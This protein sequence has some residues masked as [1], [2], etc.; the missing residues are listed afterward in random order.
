MKCPP[1]SPYEAERLVALSK[2]RLG[3]DRALP[4]LDPVVRI[5]A[6][7]FDV[8]VA[9]VN[10]V[11]D[12]HVFFAAAKGIVAEEV[13]TS[14]DASFCAHAMLENDV[15]VVADATLDARFHD[16]PLVRG[17]TRV[18]FYAGVPIYSASGMPL[19]ALCIIDQKPNHH[20]SPDDSERLR[21][22][23]RM[24]T[25]RL[26]LRR[27]EMAAEMD[28]PTHAAIDAMSPTAMIR[29]DRYGHIVN[30]NISAAT[31]YGYDFDAWHGLHIEALIAERDRAVLRALI[32]QVVEKGTV[33]GMT[34]PSHLHGLSRNGAEFLLGFS[35]FC[36]YENGALTFNA[37][38][39]N[40]SILRHEKE[41]LHRLS[42]VDVLT[43]AVTRA[44][45]YRQTEQALAAAHPVTV[46]IL[47]LDN[48]KNINDGLG[49]TVGDRVLIEV[50]RRLK[51]VVGTA[52]T[53]ARIGADE[54]GVL[55]PGLRGL[56][57]IRV[58][59]ETLTASIALPIRVDGFDVRVTACAGVAAAPEHGQEALEVIGAADLAVQKAKR[60]GRGQTYTFAAALRT[61]AVARR[62]YNIELQRAVS[63]SEFVLFYQPQVNLS[64]GALSGVEALIRWQHPQR[65]LLS[66][67][68]FLSSLEH[69]PLASTVGAWVLDEACAQAA[70][71][72][73]NGLPNLR[74]GVNLFGVQFRV[75]HIVDE[76][77]DALDR[78]GLPPQA[79]ELEITENVALDDDLVLEAIERLHA[80]HVGIAFDD[81]G[82][83]YAS[84]SLLKRYPLTRIKIDRSFVM[85]MT[86]SEKDA[87]V[88]RAILDMARGFDL[89]T[90]AEGVET[91][92]QRD[93]LRRLGCEEGQGYLFGTPLPAAE[94]TDQ[95]G[96][97]PKRPTIACV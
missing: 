8:P 47:D 54:F 71:W 96:A 28:G 66:P 20:F 13:D 21:E 18:R 23:A 41:S 64:T 79:L 86:K 59:A 70:F 52:D 29:F 76:A 58:L 27:I 7:M 17:A 82:T 60:S 15:M 25:D 74:M 72:R 26:E 77:L 37:H 92:E 48:F 63:D 1:A 40:L 49:H 95:F 84:L 87:S 75:G 39:Q 38:L 56:D 78:H 90:I 6:R 33:D 51:S 5:A 11:G 34:M 68:A 81:F 53:V 83:G 69:G 14:R 80:H 35:L 42:N 16:N 89:R 45:L 50:V 24:A 67:A 43:G 91:A 57:S 2:Y 88:V 94:L 97:H 65:G 44:S 55:V 4:S 62:L 93:M 61:E 30:W 9:A 10:I 31:L 85:G 3:R 19:G 32:A 36:W 22:L 73:R 12:D 46:V